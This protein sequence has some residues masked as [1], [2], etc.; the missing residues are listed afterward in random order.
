MARGIAIHHYGG[1]QGQYH[2]NGLWNAL[3]FQENKYTSLNQAI[4]SISNALKEFANDRKLQKGLAVHVE[5]QG[6]DELKQVV[7]EK[8]SEPA[9]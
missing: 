5:K 1:L 9:C 7:H 6:N 3:Q 8:P 4:D 2:L